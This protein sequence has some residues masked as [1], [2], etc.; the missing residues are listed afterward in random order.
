MT[1]PSFPIPPEALLDDYH[2]A[3]RRHARAGK[4]PGQV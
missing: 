1:F 2:L 4:L 3:A